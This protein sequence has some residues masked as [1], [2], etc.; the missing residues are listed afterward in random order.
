MSRQTRAD[1][2]AALGAAFRAHSRAVDR[3]DEAA[4]AHL[5]I[6]RTDLA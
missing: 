5:G 4:A 6:N 2:L 3:F 1:A